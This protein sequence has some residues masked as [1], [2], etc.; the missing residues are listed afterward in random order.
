GWDEE[1]MMPRGG[2]GHRGEQMAVLAGMQH[3][4]AADPQRGELLAAAEGS[5]LVADPGSCEAANVR[6]IRR[7]FD[8]ATRLPRRLVQD[9]ARTTA[10]AQQEWVFAR[11]DADFKHFRPW[12]EKIVNLKRREADAWGYQENAYD[13]LV[14]EYEPG[15][16]S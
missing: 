13:A 16:R 10:V 2:A 7:S 6:E 1:T 8:R 15:A 5:S 9:V 14:D 11:R 3:D 12:L 4:M